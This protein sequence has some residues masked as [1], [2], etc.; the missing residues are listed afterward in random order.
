MFFSCQKIQNPDVNFL[1]DG[2]MIF[3]AGGALLWRTAE[4]IAKGPVFIQN[5]LFRVDPKE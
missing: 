1:L 3:L 2:S 4:G 5:F